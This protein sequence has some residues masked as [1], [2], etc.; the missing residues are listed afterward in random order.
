MIKIELLSNETLEEA[1]SLVG[2]VFPIQAEE[3]AS[4][5]FPASL[6]PQKFKEILRQY[7]VPELK[8]WVVI[9][10]S[11]KVVGTIGLYCYENDKHEA[12]WLGWF[13]VHPDV[14]KKGVGTRL[15]RFSIENARNQG[16]KFLRLWTST[17]PNEQD[18]HRL[19]ER[20]EFK[21]V[22]EEPLGDTGFNKLYYELKL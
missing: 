5:A 9:D 2:T 15:L 21:L 19:Y 4:V 20:H 14:R 10:S 22:G 13:C 18:A 11:G 17:S 3:P 7:Q 1:I 8:Y 12:F 16:K 6:N